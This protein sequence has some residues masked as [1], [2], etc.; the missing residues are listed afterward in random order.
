MTSVEGSLSLKEN[1]QP[2]FFHPQTVPFAIKDAIAWKIECLESTGVLEK[3]K[4]SKWASP[5]VPVPKKDGS[6]RLHGDYKVTINPTLM[7]DQ[8]PLPKPEEIFAP[9]PPPPMPGAGHSRSWICRKP[10]SA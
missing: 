4:F 7:V 2:K 5:I 10:I 8:H 3:V 1:S 6:F 9:P